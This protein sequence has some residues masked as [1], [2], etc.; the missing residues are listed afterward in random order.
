MI[1]IG[2]PGRRRKEVSKYR[3]RS[4]IAHR[5]STATLQVENGKA[6]IS[7]AEPQRAI[8]FGQSVVFYQGDKVIGGGIIGEAT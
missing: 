5:Q 4:A 7:F 8:A 2:F 3:Q 1:L 6:E